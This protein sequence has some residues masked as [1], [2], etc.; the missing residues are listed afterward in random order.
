M[1]WEQA[2]G[3][4]NTGCR[5][6]AGWNQ[7]LLCVYVCVFA[8]GFGF[9]CMHLHAD[10]H[11]CVFAACLP[12]R[13]PPPAFLLHLPHHPLTCSPKC[14]PGRQQTPMAMGE[15]PS[16]TGASL[17]LLRHVKD[18]LSGQGHWRPRPLAL[19]SNSPTSLPSSSS[20]PPLLPPPPPPS[21]PPLP[22]SP[23]PLPSSLPPQEGRM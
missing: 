7:Q 1:R 10:Q 13:P 16:S 15:L 23:P 11:M 21:P 17:S 6:G 20:P 4:G 12:S 8:S 9:M 3:E 19:M 22:P 18:M 14:S 5:L 2:G